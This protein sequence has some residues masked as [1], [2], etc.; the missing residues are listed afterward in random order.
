VLQDFGALHV[1]V[2]S[3]CHANDDGHDEN[4]P[5]LLGSLLTDPSASLAGKNLLRLST[6][7]RLGDYDKDADC[8]ACGVWCNDT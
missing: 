6:I 8:G 1:A 5:C 7:L 4:V 3:E 2:S